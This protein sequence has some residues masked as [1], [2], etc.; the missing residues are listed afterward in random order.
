MSLKDL[1]K[2][3]LFIPIK[4]EI[5][6]LQVIMPQI[7]PKWVDEIFI[8]DG[9][10]VDGSIQYLESLGHTVHQQKTKGVKQAFWEA[11][12]KIESDVII[13][14]SPDGNSLPETIPQLIAKINEGYD[15]VI[16]SRYLGTSRS[17]DDNFDSAIANRLLTKLINICFKASYT[18]ALVMY[19]AFKKKHLYALGMDSLKNEHTEIMLI[20]RG[21]RKML[22]I[23]EIASSEPARIGAPG[24]RAHPGLFGKY[25][26]GALILK[27]ILRDAIFYRP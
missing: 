6:G 20:T 24:S 3:T 9:G 15:V 8:L 22:K 5:D 16:A 10:S 12:E 25:K 14:F 21:T 1:M 2:V 19:K 18:D 23:T 7:N 17:D 27:T 26:S 13:P 4:N 11:F